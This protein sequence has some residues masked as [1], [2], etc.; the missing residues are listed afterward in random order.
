MNGETFYRHQK[1]W[2]EPIHC[3]YSSCEVSL[4]LILNSV[5]ILYIA[6]VHYGFTCTVN[7]NCSYLS[8]L[9]DYIRRDIN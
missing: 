1:W 5:K 3:A 9:D 2:T 7:L 8:K 6:R 4:I